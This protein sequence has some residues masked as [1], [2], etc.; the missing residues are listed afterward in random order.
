MP[1]YWN[2][3]NM[4]ARNTSHEGVGAGTLKCVTGHNHYGLRNRKINNRLVENRFP[5]CDEIETWEHVTSCEVIE[6]IKEK[7]LKNLEEKIKKVHNI[8]HLGN[9]IDWMLGDTKRRL[10]REE[11]IEGNTT[12]SI[13]GISN[14]FRG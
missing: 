3:I 10:N 5:K 1:E 2:W 4:E 7:Y 6:V 9:Q 14:I 12:Q 13:F 8:E 11:E